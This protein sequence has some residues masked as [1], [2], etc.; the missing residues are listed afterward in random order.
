M[1]P[2]YCKG[3]KYRKSNITQL[4]GG[5]NATRFQTLLAKIILVCGVFFSSKNIYTKA[6]IYAKTVLGLGDKEMKNTDFLLLMWFRA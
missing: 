6:I 5:I 4:D 1:P 2:F 3:N